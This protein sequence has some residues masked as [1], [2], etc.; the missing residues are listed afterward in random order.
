M[1]QE[2]RK[3]IAD[4]LQ[5]FLEE[6]LDVSIGSF[7]AADLSDFVIEQIGPWLYNQGVLDARA[8]LSSS[9][10][11]IVEELS[12]LEKPSPLDR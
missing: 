8:K 4:A 3:I 2:Q 10:D 12:L 11:A 7:E 6:E 1:T 5:R 9:V